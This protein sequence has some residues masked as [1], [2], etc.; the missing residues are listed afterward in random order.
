[1]NRTRLIRL[2]SDCQTNIGHTEFRQDVLFSHKRFN[3]VCTYYHIITRSRGIL[4]CWQA[5]VQ[6]C[7]IG[8]R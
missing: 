3:Y 4:R 1:M 2:E 5:T 7:R 8:Q 6:T